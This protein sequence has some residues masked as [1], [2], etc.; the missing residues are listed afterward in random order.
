MEEK[1]TIRIS[2]ELKEEIKD[3]LIPLTHLV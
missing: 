1:E 3:E 2:K